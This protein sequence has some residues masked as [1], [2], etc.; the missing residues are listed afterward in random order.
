MGSK[1]TI[2]L[3]QACQAE[4]L[5]AALPSG[6][7]P[8]FCHRHSWP[9]LGSHRSVHTI[10]LQAR[11]VFEPCQR[12]ELIAAAAGYWAEEAAGSPQVPLAQHIHGQHEAK[13]ALPGA[14]AYWSLQEPQSAMWWQVQ[15]VS[16]RLLQLHE[17]LGSSKDVDVASML[18]RE[19]RQALGLLPAA[20]AVGF[21]RC[22][23][24][25]QAWSMLHTLCISRCMDCYL[26]G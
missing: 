20:G 22:C 12:K 14:T 6:K 23:R 16:G 24:G 2:A 3:G 18:I 5:T 21:C 26:L 10:H 17:L 11:G 4:I 8:R 15:Q 9:R 13:L 19:P 7:L 1:Q 25:L